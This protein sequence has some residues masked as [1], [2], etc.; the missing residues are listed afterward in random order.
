MQIVLSELLLMHFVSLWSL[1][2]IYQKIKFCHLLMYL[3]CDLF[4]L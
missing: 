1:I 4:G 3:K 2:L